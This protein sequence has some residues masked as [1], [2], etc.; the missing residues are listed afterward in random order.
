M[1]ERQEDQ[2]IFVAEGRRRCGA[3]PQ[4]PLPGIEKFMTP[5]VWKAGLVGEIVGAAGEGVDSRDV[6]SH[7][8]GQ[9]A[10]RNGKVLVV[11]SRDTL[12]VR[13]GATERRTLRYHSSSGA[14]AR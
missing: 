8:G 9:E 12:A 7:R 3:D 4:T 11:R 1:A 2:V 6:W 13:I 10:R 5:V 14:P